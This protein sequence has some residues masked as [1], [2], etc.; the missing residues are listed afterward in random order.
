MVALEKESVVTGVC[1]DGMAP[2]LIAEAPGCFL[3]SSPA[4]PIELRKTW[5]L[6]DLILEGLVNHLLMACDAP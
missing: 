6:K 2:S 5:E 1:A 3:L 4:K